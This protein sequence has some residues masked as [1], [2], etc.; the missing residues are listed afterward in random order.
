MRPFARNL[1]IRLTKLPRMYVVCP[2]WGHTCILLLGRSYMWCEKYW[3]ATAH[4]NMFQI[5]ITSIQT[6]QWNDTALKCN[7]WCGWE[8]QFHFFWMSF[9]KMLRLQQY[10]VKTFKKRV[11]NRMDKENNLAVTK[12]VWSTSKR[13][14]SC[15]AIS[16]WPFPK[17]DCYWIEIFRRVFTHLFL[18]R[19]CH[20]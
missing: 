6:I 5:N 11:L 7:N 12:I 4:N 16:Q 1:R 10:W 15:Q 20:R 19:H 13:A 17:N 3:L 2:I 8:I 18:R 14:I 9:L